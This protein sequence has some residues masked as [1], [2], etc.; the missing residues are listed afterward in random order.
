MRLRAPEPRFEGR[1][2]MYERFYGFRERPFSL[3]PDPSY[4]YPSRVHREALSHLRYGIEGHAG[5]TVITGE[6]GC[7]KTTLLQ[8]LLRS[9]DRKTSISRLMNTMLDSRELLEA[10]M[11]DFGLDPGQGRSKPYLIRD[12]AQFLVNERKAGRLALLII[13]EAQNLSVTALEEVRMLS[14]FETEK[15]K[16]IQ[17][18]LV[19]QP[20]LRD[21]LA[22]HDLEQ[23]RQR[24]TVSY[25]IEPLTAEE[26]H[27]YVNHRLR[28]ASVATPLT[29][30]RPVTDLIHA[31]SRGVAR[32]INVIAD[33]V[34]LYGY[35][36][37][38]H[39]I[40]LELTH[41]VV[42]DLGLSERT[43]VTTETD[44]A[45]SVGHA[46]AMA[47][48]PAAADVLE[49][50][51]DV[52]DLAL[53]ASAPAIDIAGAD[54][55][56]VTQ[57]RPQ[58]PA[59]TGH[60]RAGDMPI[61]KVHADLPLQP[62]ASPAPASIAPVSRASSSLRVPVES[63]PPRQAPPQPR[64]WWSRLRRRGMS[65]EPRSAVEVRIR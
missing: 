53:I 56:E 54:V 1:L 16:L 46:A 44:H 48:E 21:L 4:L 35:G 24:V 33:A 52:R 15:S 6:I 11:L 7:G 17:I 45:A 64:S 39:V 22:R 5:F 37:D 14:N 60:V 25:H 29:F 38:K 61:R 65:G 58:P 57:I 2:I 47:K 63:P 26:T 18:V 9:L 23:L 41:E 12:L 10:I 43:T 55:A 13:D 59:S 19:G 8:T 49:T 20:N 32:T 34:L 40:D 30:S 31:H 62:A 28:H 3:T 50:P 42:S 51:I 36:S 27:A